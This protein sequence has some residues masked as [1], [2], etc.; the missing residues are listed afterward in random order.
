MEEEEGEEGD[1]ESRGRDHNED[2]D[3]DDDDD[4]GEDE[5]NDDEEDEIDEE[6]EEDADVNPLSRS[7]RKPSPTSRRSTSNNSRIGRPHI[8]KSGDG[9]D[10][11]MEVE[12]GAEDV[13]GDEMDVDDDV[14]DDHAE[15]SATEEDYPR[16]QF[17]HFG[18]PSHP[19]HTRPSSVSTGIS[20]WVLDT[21]GDK[22]T[23]KDA[24]D[25]ALDAGPSVPP[26]GAVSPHEHSPEDDDA[27]PNG[28][29]TG[30]VGDELE[31]DGDI[32][33]DEE[34][35][36][37]DPDVDHPDH[38]E[39]PLVEVD[40]DEHTAAQ[41]DRESNMDEAADEPDDDPDLQPA[42]RAEA[43]DVLATIEIKFAK[44][45]ERVYL[46]K[47]EG[48]AW[49]EGLIW[50]GKYRVHP[51]LHHLQ[52]E[53]TKRRDKRLMLAERKKAYEI[54]A[55]E[56]KRKEEEANILGNWDYA[57]NELQTEMVAETNRKRRKLERERRAMER[58]AGARRIPV[59]IFNPPP[60]PTLREIAITMPLPSHLAHLV[61]NANK[62]SSGSMA[63]FAV[64][65]GLH[66]G[67]NGLGPNATAYPDLPMLTPADIA[68]DLDYIF[69]HR[70]AGFGYAYG[71]FPAV[72]GVG[73]AGVGP[74]IGPGMG[75]GPGVAGATLGFNGIH[76]V[77]FGM[78]GL[79]PAEMYPS[80][81]GLAHT[82]T[83][84]P[85]PA[86]PSVPP[87]QN[88]SG[89]TGPGVGPTDP[90]GFGQGV[91][92]PNAVRESAYP[93]GP[94]GAG[95]V[96][97]GPTTSRRTPRPSG[98]TIDREGQRELALR[99]RDR[100]LPQRDRERELSQ[101]DRDVRERERGIEMNQRERDKEREREFGPNVGS[102]YSPS[103]WNT[104]PPG[105]MDWGLERRREEDILDRERERDRE[106]TERDRSQA[107]TMTPPHLPRHQNSHLHSHSHHPHSSHPQH[108][109]HSS[110]PSHPPHSNH[111]SH[112]QSLHSH[113]HHQYQ[114]PHPH[115][116]HSHSHTQHQHGPAGAA[117][118]HHVGQHHH[119]RHHHHIVHH[120]HSSG[121]ES[122][123]GPAS[124]TGVEGSGVRP[125]QGQ[126]QNSTTMEIINL[127]ANPSSKP[128][129][130]REDGKFT[131]GSL[132][133]SRPPSTHPPFA[134]YDERERERDRDRD[135]E[136]ER[137]RDRQV[138]T[139]FVLGPSHNSISATSSPRLNWSHGDM[140][141]PPPGG[142]GALFLL[143]SERIHL[144][145]PGG[146]GASV[147][148][149]RY[150]NPP[151]PSHLHRQSPNPLTKSPS[152]PGPPAS[153]T[154]ASLPNPG[155]SSSA[156]SPGPF[157]I[158]RKS[159]P[160][161]PPPSKLGMPPLVFSPRLVG[162]GVPTGPGVPGVLSSTPAGP[163]I[164]GGLSSSP[165]G[166]GILT[167]GPGIP[168]TLALLSNSSGPGIS[169]P[170]GPGLPPAGPNIPQSG[171]GVPPVGP[172]DIPGFP[173]NNRTTSPLI[174]LT[175][176]PRTGAPP[177]QKIGVE[178]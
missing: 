53:L 10:E 125:G 2:D 151:P 50:Q 97:S 96:P 16:R 167:S 162:P 105:G 39:G 69:Q 66:I 112:P 64:D 21:D 17:S 126:G 171:P 4:E 37:T 177:G 148:P 90:S 157:T 41:D 46:E 20:R 123:T 38:L 56:R 89:I 163:G 99:E 159:S 65:G 128:V 54:S 5:E 60:A 87:P 132:P 149:H 133:G 141:G 88:H 49:E 140:G 67:S 116:Q 45:R 48:L 26:S 70:R 27:E 100:D 34:P 72:P 127:S 43:L 146:P 139:P 22:V 111:Q 150:S 158:P 75:F 144:P 120:H 156:S 74:G 92:Q 3:D 168:P 31:G 33:D 145:V 147:G 24:I 178:G 23:D 115:S 93:M 55:L 47:M 8:T 106:R 169:P 122:R 25:D 85:T 94:G 170:G 135:R 118:H 78:N 36:P 1:P 28:D 59:P 11:D 108:P 104:K 165:P 79:G 80:G 172:G 176:Q 119:H 121:S 114:H 52:E 102:V 44:L 174:P 143:P 15:G 136:R 83:V 76:G 129:W 58:P 32:V 131:G 71:M 6:D 142:P 91:F 161:L 134:A 109:S 7:R 175:S 18:R 173:G 110:H 73:F 29:A 40:G 84:T 62:R 9:A 81:S 82:G 98:S 51:E 160:V 35:S 153:P 14:A 154:S 117:H 68:T 57:R 124:G 95:L 152:R 155:I 107:Q 19:K 86:G 12:M 103:G 113:S 138:A 101:R 63:K 61:S 30:D 130:K 77:G 137:D 13:E 164:P 166:P 42:H